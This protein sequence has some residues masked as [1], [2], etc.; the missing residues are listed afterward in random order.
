[1]NKDGT[2]VEGV[3]G[4]KVLGM[5]DMT[6]KLV[7]LGCTVQSGAATVWRGGSQKER[8]HVKYSGASRMR[9]NH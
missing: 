1:M 5:R 4:L 3:T 2:G 7:F 6:Y 9:L 8:S